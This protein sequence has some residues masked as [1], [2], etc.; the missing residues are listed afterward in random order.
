MSW[1]VGIIGS[2]LPIVANQ[3][4]DSSVVLR[5]CN[6]LN[7]NNNT[8]WVCY[9][10]KT[11][12][13]SI[14]PH[15]STVRSPQQA[16]GSLIKTHFASKLSLSYETRTHTPATTNCNSRSNHRVV[17]NY[18][19]RPLIIRSVAIPTTTIGSLTHV[20][21]LLFGSC[22]STVAIDVVVV[23]AVLV[24]RVSLSLYRPDRIYHVSV[25][26]CYDKK[27]EASRSDFYNDQLASKD[28][29]CV[30]TSLEITDILTE[31]QIDLCS[32]PVSPLDSLY[33]LR[34]VRSPNARTCMCMC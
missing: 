6:N 26:P 10:E 2:T 19:T 31:K 28:V 32:L 11:Q 7:T 34:C 20:R 9:A 1:Y 4:T 29:D 14:I 5:Q 15:M 8:G 16:M 3:T 27:L 22:C 24:V 25:M 23:I 18:N 17:I 12:G 30:L 13:A 21:V 33:A